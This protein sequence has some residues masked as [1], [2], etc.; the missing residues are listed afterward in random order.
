[1]GFWH[2]GYMDFHDEVGLDYSFR[3]EKLVF[4]CQHCDLAFDSM[5]ELRRHR[6]Q[7]HPYIRPLLFV[8]GIELG[9]APYRL[10]RPASTSDFVVERCS[11]AAM[12][13][14]AIQ[15]E[16]IPKRLAQVTN[17]KVIVELVNEGSSAVYELEFSIANEKHLLGVEAS[18]LNLA[19]KRELTTKTIGTF[20]HECEPF[21][22]AKAY[23]D[24]LC[25]YLYGV[26]AK[27]RAVDSSLPYETYQE[28]FNRAADTLKD[29][30][31]P[32]AGFVRG[33]VA[34]H[35][36]HFSDA[37]EFSPPGRL[38]MAAHR[39]AAVLDGLNWDAESMNYNKTA[40]APEDLLTDH[41]TLPILR[42][43][44]TTLQNLATEVE[45]IAAFAKRE[46]PE[47]DQMK[48]HILLAEACAASGDAVLAKKT[49]RELIGNP[50]TAG[51][52]ERLIARL[53]TEGKSI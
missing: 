32:L 51:W 1:M 27:E 34:F 7:S 35:F 53:T 17:D 31:R 26:M 13:G 4:H 43:G 24:G 30:D 22:T 49:A 42:W 25:H 52:A 14:K 9:A 12:N 41:E 2:T 16:Q 3:P 29:Y 21:N 48:L 45:H 44:E 23:Y 36:N 5:D 18:F 46:M 6:F 19:K 38:N 33:L 50:K 10:T 28:R 37:Y 39:F 8:R 47:F 40:S 20:I 11:K 15:P